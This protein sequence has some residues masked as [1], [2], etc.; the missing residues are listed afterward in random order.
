M[1]L[2]SH[3]GNLNGKMP[4]NEN[5]PEYIDEAIHAGYDV[6]IDVWMIEGVLLLGHDTPQYGVS[7]LWLNQRYGKLWI[8]C[9]NMEAMEWFN[10]VGGFNYFWHE[11]DAVTLTSKNFIWAFPGKQPIQRSIAVLP[12]IYNDNLDSCI[13]ICSDYIENYKIKNNE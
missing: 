12:E 5:H 10:G 9:K 11:T 7:Q 6:E 3:R 4:Q 2:I 1:K 13:G 8:H